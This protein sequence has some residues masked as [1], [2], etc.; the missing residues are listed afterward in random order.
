MIDYHSLRDFIAAAERL[1]ETRTL[2][3][4]SWDLELACINQITA[5]QRGP[6]LV[7]DDIPGHARGFRVATNVMTS[8]A[9]TRLALGLDQSLGPVQVLDQWRKM[10][11]RI[12]P[13]APMEVPDAPIRQNVLTGDAVDLTR[14]P[15][16]R[17]HPADGGRYVNTGGLIITRDPD[18]GWINCA[19]NRGMLVGPNEVGL[20]IGAAGQ[21][22]TIVLKYRS[23]RQPCP[24]A[25]ALSPDPILMIAGGFKVPW[26]Q[27]EYEFAGGLRKHPVPVTKGVATGLPVPAAAEIVLEGEIEPG[28]SCDEGPFGEWTGYITGSYKKE[29]GFPHLLRVKSVMFMDDPILL[30]VRPLKPPA[31]WYAV[32]PITQAA[33]IWN[34]L[35]A[36]GHRGVKAVW[37]HLLESFGAVWTVIAVEQLYKGHAKEVGLAA[38]VCPAANGWGAFTIVVDDDVDVTN[39]EEVLWTLAMRCRLERDVHVV[40]GV[41]SSSLFPWVTEEERREGRVT[42]SR[43]V[44]DACKDFDRKDSYPPVNEFDAQFRADVAEKWRLLD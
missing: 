37:T 5:E 24:V 6:L 40:S 31:P 11:R 18:E 23:R 38:T 4:A 33:G 2:H 17:W 13:V 36:G 34:Q 30:G 7:F 42:G 44:F 22:S 35:E 16:P 9:R 29:G 20:Q 14:F 28:A 41:R 8:L 25:I 26:G 39:L 21:N 15:L 3:G 43:L 10:L 32:V 27:S 12:E 19:I 1:G